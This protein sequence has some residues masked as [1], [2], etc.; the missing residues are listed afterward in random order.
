MLAPVLP[1][2]KVAGDRDNADSTI[3]FTATFTLFVAPLNAA[4]IATVAGCGTPDVWHVKVTD[5]A[6]AGTA[7]EAGAGTN[8][9]SL[10]VNPTIA[11]PGGAGPFSETFP[12]VAAPPAME[13][14]LNDSA[15][16]TAGLIV[17]ATLFVTPE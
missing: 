7:T 12:V 1:L 11:P 9:V 5:V 13:A 3:G 6:P 4:V 2:T 10:L 15:D 17:N 8:A 14:G 16:S